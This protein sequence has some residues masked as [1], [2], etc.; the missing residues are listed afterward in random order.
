MINPELDILGLKERF[1]E[2]EILMIDNFCVSYFALKVSNYL[3][4][5]PK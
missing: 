4:D 5:L 2:K 1:S 3:N